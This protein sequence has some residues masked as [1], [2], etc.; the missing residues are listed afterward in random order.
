M[1]MPSEFVLIQG[2]FFQYRESLGVATK[3]VEGTVAVVKKCLGQFQFAGVI[4][5]DPWGVLSGGMNDVF[6]EA[7][8]SDI[9]IVEQTLRFK[10]KYVDRDYV[11]QYEFTK[12]PDGTWSGSYASAATGT[13]QARCVL[14]HVNRNFFVPAG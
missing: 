5:R 4:E 13:G 8:L 11:I 14:T 12:Q 2:V 9:T 6:G 3:P 1:P 10:K 7:E